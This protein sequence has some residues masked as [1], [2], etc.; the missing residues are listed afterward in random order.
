MAKNKDD[1][2]EIYI[3]NWE[4]YQPKISPKKSSWMRLQ[5][6]FFHDESVFGLTSYQIHTLLYLYTAFARSFCAVKYSSR[7]NLSKLRVVTGIKKCNIYKAL[8]ALKERGL[9][10]FSTRTNVQGPASLTDVIHTPKK[11]IQEKNSS[12]KILKKLE[13]TPDDILQMWNDLGPPYRK[14]TNFPA[15]M[16]EDFYD[17]LK[18]Y[19]DTQFWTSLFFQLKN[20]PILRGEAKNAAGSKSVVTFSKLSSIKFL[21][22]IDSGYLKKEKGKWDL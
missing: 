6:D 12:E 2:I 9:I 14:L 3:K 20:N 17:V 18:A 10:D 11:N 22:L 13:I 16:M 21:S 7:I 15:M 1:F 5:L 19:Q 4:K 8:D